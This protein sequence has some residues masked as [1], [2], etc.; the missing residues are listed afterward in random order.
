MKEYTKELEIELPDSEYG[1]L[2]ALVEVQAHEIDASFDHEFGTKHE[3]EIEIDDVWIIEV[4]DED[5][6]NC[7]VSELR[8]KIELLAQEKFT[9]KWQ[10]GDFN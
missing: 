1:L 10:N 4:T 2:L 8:K 3:R 5:G 6:Q 7:K 9:E